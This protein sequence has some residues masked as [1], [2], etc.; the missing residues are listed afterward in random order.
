MSSVRKL[1]SYL[2]RVL[3][4]VN[5]HNQLSLNCIFCN[6]ILS[7]VLHEQYIAAVM[8]RILHECEGQ[9]NKYGKLSYKNISVT[10]LDMNKRHF[11]QTSFINEGSIMLY[12]CNIFVFIIFSSVSFCSTRL[13]ATFAIS[14]FVCTVQHLQEYTVI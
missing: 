7:M 9:R 8:N 3:V 1:V 12:I 4:E 13:T 6:A 5:K 10:I 14:K 11:P 2:D